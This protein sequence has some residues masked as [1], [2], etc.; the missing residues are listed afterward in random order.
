MQHVDPVAFLAAFA[1]L[2]VAGTTA[3]VCP[4]LTTLRSNPIDALRHQ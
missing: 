3:A 1:V 2:A 4:A